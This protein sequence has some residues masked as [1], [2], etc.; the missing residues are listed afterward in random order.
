MS[1]HKSDRKREMHV[2][3]ETEDGK[4]IWG[5][6][7]LNDDERLQD[8]LNDERVFLPINTLIQRRKGTA[9]G[10]QDEY[11]LTII[12]KAFINKIEELQHD[13]RKYS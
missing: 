8:I 9:T 12:K 5:I 4:T 1:E 2:S 13:K 10:D 11:K 3:I 7:F 6:V